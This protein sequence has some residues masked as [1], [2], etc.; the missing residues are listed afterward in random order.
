MPDRDGIKKQP[1]KSQCINSKGAL[2]LLVLEGKGRHD[3]LASGQMLHLQLFKTEI[4]G[5][6]LDKSTSLGCDK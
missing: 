5:N 1:H 2:D 4:N 6:S 3:C